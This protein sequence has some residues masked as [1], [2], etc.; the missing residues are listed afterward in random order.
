M[1]EKY[2]KAQIPALRYD[3]LIGNICGDN[4]R[5]YSRSEMNGALGVAIVQSILDGCTDDLASVA[6]HLGL[7][8]D[9]IREAFINLDLNG[10]F[11]TY[12]GKSAILSD[13]KKLESKD[14][15]TWCYYA[16]Y[17]SGYVGPYKP[18]YAKV[19]NG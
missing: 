17:A 18:H 5:K 2:E 12:G 1:R 7:Y 14:K 4:W 19:N 13:R 8:K 16:G 15:T 3:K 11:N 9:Q 10:V 6:N